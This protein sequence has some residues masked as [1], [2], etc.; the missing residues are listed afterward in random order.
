[1]IEKLKAF[2]T[3]SLKILETIQIARQ[4][5][6]HIISF[7]FGID[8]LRSKEDQ[9]CQSP[10]LEIEYPNIQLFNLVFCAIRFYQRSGK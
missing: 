10:V 5:P 3:S 4:N 1:M 9:N 8:K 7:E 2:Q 6:L